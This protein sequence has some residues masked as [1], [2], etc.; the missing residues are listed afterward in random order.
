MYEGPKADR[1]SNLEWDKGEGLE[2]LVTW[3][4]DPLKHYID[5]MERELDAQGCNGPETTFTVILNEMKCKVEDMEETLYRFRE[6]F[7]TKE[8]KA[9][10]QVPVSED[11]RA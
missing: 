10:E 11:S 7:R 1:A 3:G 5:S 4:I 2:N 9:P 6:E 8:G